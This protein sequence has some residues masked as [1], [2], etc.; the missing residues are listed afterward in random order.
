M[1][2]RGAFEQKSTDGSLTDW[3]RDDASKSIDVMDAY[4]LMRNQLAGYEF[5]PPIAK[6]PP[7]IIGGVAVSV[8]CDILIHGQI[9]GSPY[10]GAALMRLTKPDEEESS[11]AKSKRLEMGLYAA[12]LVLI[13]TQEFHDNNVPVSNEFCWSLDIQS[14]EINRAPR[15]Y[16]NRKNNLEAACEVIAAMWDK[17]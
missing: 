12:T 16:A 10:R 7:F 3:V 1:A 9:K 13:Y 15:N 17:V 2:A 11:A 6:Q 4:L 8:N 5:L 14:G